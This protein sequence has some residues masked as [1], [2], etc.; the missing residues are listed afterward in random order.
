MKMKN[1]FI[2]ATGTDVGK[3]YTTLKLLRI[4]AKQ[5]LKVAAFKPIETGVDKFPKDAA[6]LLEVSQKLNPNLKT[7]T[8]LDICP[9]QLTLPAAPSVAIGKNKIDMKKIISSYKK[10]QLHCDIILIEGAGGLFTPIEKDFYMIDLIKT[11]EATALLVVHDKLGCI[12]DALLSMNAL[13]QQK[14][15]FEWCINFLHDKKEFEKITLPFFQEKFGKVLSVQDDL[16]KI[17]NNLL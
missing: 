10:L 14:I 4:F 15:D 2:T 7:F 5:N 3:T 1:I 8:L 6:K 12:N 17:A 9:I 13:N 11:F 16:E